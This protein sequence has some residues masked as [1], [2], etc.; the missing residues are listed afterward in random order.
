MTYTCPICGNP[1][2]TY[3]PYSN[4]G[5]SASDEICPCCGFQFGF[6]DHVSGHTHAAWR[7]HWVES[8]MPWFSRGRRPPPGWDPVAQLA[9]QIAA[10]DREAFERR[11]AH[12][13]RVIIASS[14][15]PPYPTGPSKP[16][17]G[18]GPRPPVRTR[19]TAERNPIKEYDAAAWEA[20]PGQDADNEKA[21]A[22]Y[23]DRLARPVA[24]VTDTIGQLIATLPDE[25]TRTIPGGAVTVTKIGTDDDGHAQSTVHLA[26]EGKIADSEATWTWQTAGGFAAV[27]VK[28]GDRAKSLVAVTFVRTAQ[29][30][31]LVCFNPHSG[32]ILP[33][34]NSNWV[35]TA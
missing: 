11:P 25:L 2:L 21:A 4:D 29:N 17:W 20:P 18:D 27:H 31:G 10:E 30:L 12:P 5:T 35:F 23:Q 14:T 28:G 26:G 3:R 19:T 1:N 6:D 33:P 13:Q 7:Q 24:W 16:P 22:Y 9:A 32:R 8:G 15:F 34:Q